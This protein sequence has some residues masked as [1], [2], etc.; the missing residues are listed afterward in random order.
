MDLYLEVRQ[1]EDDGDFNLEE[2]PQTQEW[3]D[4]MQQMAGQSLSEEEQAAM[5][6]MLAEMGGATEQAEEMGIE[7]GNKGHNTV[8]ILEVYEGEV[9]IRSDTDVGTSDDI[10]VQ[11]GETYMV[12]GLKP[13][14]KNED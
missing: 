13:P 3:L 4:S 11:P 14:V 8:T 5:A 9:L 7:I 10:R 2:L 1:N 6:E 12:D